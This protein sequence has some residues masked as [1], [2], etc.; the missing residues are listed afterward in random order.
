MTHTVPPRTGRPPRHRRSAARKT[1][2][3]ESCPRTGRV[4]PRSVPGPGPC[5]EGAASPYGGRRP[6]R[7]SR[8]RPGPPTA[9]NV[10]GRPLVQAQHARSAHLPHCHPPPRPEPLGRRR[11]RRRRGRLRHGRRDDHLRLGR[12]R[13]GRG[14]RLRVR[15]RLVHQHRQRLL[16]RPAVLRP[17]LGRLRRRAVRLH[18]RPGHQEPADRDRRARPGGPGRGRVA[19]LRRPALRRR[20]HLG[21]PRGRG[22]GGGPR[23]GAA[24]PRAPR[25]RPAGEPLH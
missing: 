2:L 22:A 20:R 5:R 18:R 25:V 16:R 8:A 23:A 11:R 12:H 19:Q 3:A 6:K 9:H 15:R 24:G 1:P 17:D 14:R 4:K 13:L 7:S 21:R 10:R